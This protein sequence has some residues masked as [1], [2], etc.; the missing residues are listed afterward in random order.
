MP[1]SSSLSSL[2]FCWVCFSLAF[3][4]VFQAFLTTFLVEYDYKTPIRNIETWKSFSPPLLNLTTYQSTVSFSRK[5][6]KRKQQRYKSHVNCPS[7]PVCENWAK[8][9]RNVSV[10]LAD[11]YAE[12]NYASGHYVGEN[13]EPL[14][15]R[16]EDAVVYSTGLTMVMFYGDPLRRLVTDVIVR[17]VEAGIYKYWVSTSMKLCVLHSRKIAIFRKP[18]EYYSFNLYHMQ[19]AF[20]LLLMDWCLSVICFLIEVL[21][22]HLSGIRI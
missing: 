14:L 18:D 21:Y 10:L 6:T 7:L 4:T 8:N 20:Y 22:N 9:Q 17:V 1:L 19:F 2:L 12:V 16:L 3:S 15:C 13:S 11:I 5:V